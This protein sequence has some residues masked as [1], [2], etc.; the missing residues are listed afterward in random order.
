MRIN[1]I[2]LIMDPRINHHPEICNRI[3]RLLFSGPTRD[4]EGEDPV[5]GVALCHHLDIGPVDQ[6]HLLLQLAVAEWHLF[7]TDQ[8]HLLTQVFR[9]DPV[10][11]QIGKGGSECPSGMA[12]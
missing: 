11:G 12:R 10:E 7:T 1:W 8:R 6:V 3:K 5:L 9:A 2:S 4:R